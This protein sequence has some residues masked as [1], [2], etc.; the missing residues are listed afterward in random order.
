MRLGQT[1]T[2]LSASKII[3]SG[4]GFISTV[5][6]ARKLGESVL[7]QYALVLTLVTWFSLVGKFGFSKALTKRISE[8]E[9]QEAFLGAGILTL[10]TIF[11][12][13]LIVILIA[14]TSVERYVGAEVSEIIIFLIG[15]GLAS[16]L[17]SSVLQG[18]HLVHISGIISTVER[19]IRTFSQ[20]ALVMVGFDLAGLLF[21]YAISGVISAIVGLFYIGISPSL[22][23]REHIASLFEFAKYAWLGSV[24]NKTFD[25]VDIVLLGLFVPSALIGIYS[26]TW[27]IAMFLNIFGRAITSTL[28]PEM[29]KNAAN[30][31]LST[32]RE[33]TEE[34]LQYSGLVTLPGL[35][36]AVAIGDR[37]MRVYGPSFERGT[38]VLTILI[39]AAFIYGYV[40]QLRST[41]NAINRPD[42]AFRVNAVFIGINT[43]LNVT[44]IWQFGWV[45][46]AVATLFSTFVGLLL[47]YRYVR[48]SVGVAFPLL[49]VGRQVVA[50]LTMGS[51]VFALRRLLEANWDPQSNAMFVGLLVSAGAVVY[52]GVLAAVWPDFRLTV[53]NNLPMERLPR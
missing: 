49:S 45:G 3:G 43:V 29:S 33:L 9:N 21:G 42:L 19:T 18:K 27:S 46:A 2:I 35:V 32:V 4:L 36:G 10:G 24:G 51:L 23:G 5:Y 50:A 6:F 11:T 8:G 47:A 7:G 20:V 40:R 52:F 48:S 37:L 15:L 14:R 38:A 44:L 1:S 34:S 31:D 13:V 12:L 39:G 17:T 25:S 30:D 16:T 41:L 28:F 22:P 26:V 53:V